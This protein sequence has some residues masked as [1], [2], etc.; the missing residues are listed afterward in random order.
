MLT[1]SHIWQACVH[2]KFSNIENTKNLK[3]AHKVITKY[4]M[5]VP[6]PTYMY[7]GKTQGESVHLLPHCTLDKIALL[8]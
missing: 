8:I 1:E 4:Y 6:E 5:C 7:S 3:A 2:L